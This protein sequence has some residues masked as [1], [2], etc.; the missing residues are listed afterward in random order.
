M[1]FLFISLTK[2]RLWK[3][4]WRNREREERDRV[5]IRYLPFP[6]AGITAESILLLPDI[7]KLSENWYLDP[8]DRS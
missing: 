3:D 6:D 8:L 5:V 1:L 2:E 7:R 4:L